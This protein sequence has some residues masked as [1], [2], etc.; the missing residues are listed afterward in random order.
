[1]VI[2][3]GAILGWTVSDFVSNGL[4]RSVMIPGSSAS[5]LQN[6]MVPP[7]QCHQLFLHINTLLLENEIQGSTGALQTVD[8]EELREVRWFFMPA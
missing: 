4:M 8:F 1:M 5:S 7:K 3:L 2:V 6:E